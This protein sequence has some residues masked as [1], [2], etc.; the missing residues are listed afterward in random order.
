MAYGFDGLKMAE[1]RASTDRENLAPCRL[2]Q[3]LGFRFLHQ[4]RVKGRDTLLYGVM[5]HGWKRPAFRFS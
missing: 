3:R 5:S 1:V 4:T 2:I